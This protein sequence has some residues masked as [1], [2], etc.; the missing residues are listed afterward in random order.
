VNLSFA[1]LESFI[2]F[3]LIV[4]TLFE[5][6]EYI[7]YQTFILCENQEWLS[8]KEYLDLNLKERL[9]VALGVA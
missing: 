8:D 6:L 2:V 3:K 1:K 7:F 9:R 5:W 4:Q